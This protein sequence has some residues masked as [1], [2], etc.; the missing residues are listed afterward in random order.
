MLFHGA[1][2]RA[3]MKNM[4][5]ELDRKWIRKRIKKGLCEISGVPFDL[6]SQSG[7]LSPRAP[8]LDRIV[9]ELGYTKENSRMIC[10]ALNALF[11]T[12]GEGAAIE[13]V[14]PYLK[15]RG[16]KTWS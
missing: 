12:W 3:R 14:L 7:Q 4:E 5:F 10:R 2:R 8:T 1:K 11:G 13:V 9:P 16:I 15:K 6:Q